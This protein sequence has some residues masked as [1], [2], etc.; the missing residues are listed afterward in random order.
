MYKGFRKVQTIEKTGKIISAENISKENNNK[1][2]GSEVK[3]GLLPNLTTT[4]WREQIVCLVTSL[5]KLG[6]KSVKGLNLTD[7][8]SNL[9]Q[10]AW[11]SSCLETEL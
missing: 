9:Y 5:I 2:V 10:P 8:I 6:T 1:R 3:M 11:A 7:R 4:H